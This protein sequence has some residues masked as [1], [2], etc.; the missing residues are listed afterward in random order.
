MLFVERKSDRFQVRNW[1]VYIHRTI[2]VLPGN[3]NTNLML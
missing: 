3:I 2:I 1:K